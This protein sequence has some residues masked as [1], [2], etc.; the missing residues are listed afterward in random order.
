[1]T[2]PLLL[3]SDIFRFLDFSFFSFGPVFSARSALFLLLHPLFSLFALACFFHS[4][5][6]PKKKTVSSPEIPICVCLFL[7]SSSEEEEGEIPK[8]T[9]LAKTV[10]PVVVGVSSLRLSLL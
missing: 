9:F 8:F 5:K 4:Q 10:K 6:A 7:S 1:M 2:L 3:R